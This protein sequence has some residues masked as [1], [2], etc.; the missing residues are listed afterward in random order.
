VA[1]N[2]TCFERVVRAALFP[3][4]TTAYRCYYK[5]IRFILRSARNEP[6]LKAMFQAVGLD[7]P[8]SSYRKSR[9]MRR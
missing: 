1:D 4:K 9:S 3:C 5:T 7:C 2:E 6:F 8:E